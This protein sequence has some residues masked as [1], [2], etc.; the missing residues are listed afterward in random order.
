MGE[1]CAETAGQWWWFPALVL[2]AAAAMTFI[3]AVLDLWTG[4]LPAGHGQL[5]DD[6][7]REPESSGPRALLSKVIGWVLVPA[8]FLYYFRDMVKAEGWPSASG[9]V[10]GCIVVG[11]GLWV[12]STAFER[13]GD[14]VD[15]RFAALG[16]DVPLD[17]AQAH[18]VA[19]AR[20]LTGAALGVS[21][22]GFVVI[23][24]VYAGTMTDAACPV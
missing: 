3:P 15:L 5:G 19:R 10:G 9:V 6:D 13:V 22:L 7:A 11:A 8:L 24:A 21:A 2:C 16:S 4:V 20:V 14:V 18:R 1:A 17:A 23:L 12:L